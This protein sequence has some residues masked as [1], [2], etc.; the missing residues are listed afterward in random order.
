MAGLEEQDT[1]ELVAGAVIEA[2]DLKAFD[3]DFTVN[4]WSKVA[5]SALVRDASAD[6]VL[7]TEPAVMVPTESNILAAIPET[8]SNIQ[9]PAGAPTATQGH[10]SRD[11][12][13]L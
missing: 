6:G 13:A 10:S 7:M 8:E 2:L 11:S 4:A 1:K 3:L 12:T 9:L 5:P